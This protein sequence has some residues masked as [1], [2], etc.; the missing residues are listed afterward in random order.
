MVDNFSD[1]NILIFDYQILTPIWNL[2]NLGQNLYQ[3]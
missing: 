2:L 1:F 3:K